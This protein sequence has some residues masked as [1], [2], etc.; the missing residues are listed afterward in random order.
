M[1]LLALLTTPETGIYGLQNNWNQNCRHDNKVSVETS[2]RDIINGLASVCGTGLLAVGETPKPAWSADSLDVDAFLRKGVDSGGGMGVSSQAGKSRPETGV[3]LREGSEVSRNRKTGDVNAEIVVNGVNGESMAVFV[4]YS[5]PWS[6]AEGSFYDI[7]CRNQKT[8][9]GAFVQVTTNT[10]GKSI[11][12]IDNSF[13]LENLLA[14]SGRFSFYGQPTD[15]KVKKSA[16]KEDYRIIDLSFS[17][18][19]Q[20]TQTELPRKAQLIATIP[21]GSSQAVML[22]GSAPAIRWKN[23]SDNDI[24]STVE[25]FR[26]VAAPKSSLKL[27]RKERNNFSLDDQGE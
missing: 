18:L 14:P 8:S 3:F 10:K 7:E 1:I 17:T 2:R 4:G 23:G 15:V 20:A 24:Y 9:D 12:D 13:F 21:K 6:L 19:S 16:T 27:R 25:S 26:A 11:S 22:I 5:S